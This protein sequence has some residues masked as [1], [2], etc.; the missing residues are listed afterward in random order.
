MTPNYRYKKST[1]RG[2]VLYKKLVPGTKVHFF[3]FMTHVM[4]ESRK[5]ERFSFCLPCTRRTWD[6]ENAIFAG[7]TQIL[8][9]KRDGRGWEEA[10]Y[11][12]GGVNVAESR[13]VW[14]CRSRSALQNGTLQNGTNLLCQMGALLMVFQSL[15]LILYF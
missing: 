5:L 2:L 11:C 15:R 6:Q 10:R 8:N 9:C 13:R 14:S 7:K 12:C 1:R 3:G 4:L